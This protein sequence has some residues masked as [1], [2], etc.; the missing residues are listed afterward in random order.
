MNCPKCVHSNLFKIFK[1]ERRRRNCTQFI[2]HEDNGI[3]QVVANK[4]WKKNIKEK[5]RLKKKPE[6]NLLYRNEK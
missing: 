5:D 6:E 1:N 2:S 3:N 4:R